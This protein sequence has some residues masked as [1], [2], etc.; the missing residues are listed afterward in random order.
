[1][2]SMNCFPLANLHA[3]L[4][5]WG[6]ITV[7]PGQACSLDCINEFIIQ[8]LLW[9]IKDYTCRFSYAFLSA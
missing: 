6:H 7:Q 9:L 5:F 4:N 2:Q 1:M 3:D 8:I